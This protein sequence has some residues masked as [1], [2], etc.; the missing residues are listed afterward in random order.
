MSI[1][2]EVPQTLTC[3]TGTWTGTGTITYAYQWRLDNVNISGET[4]STYALRYADEGGMIS[5]RVTATD[6]KGSRS[7]NA[8]AVGPVTLNNDLLSDVV[9]DL[10]EDTLLE[11]DPLFEI[12]EVV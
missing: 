11:I 8:V 9:E 3:S 2:T 7:A 5:C 6:D 1:I 10:F 12:E 4:S